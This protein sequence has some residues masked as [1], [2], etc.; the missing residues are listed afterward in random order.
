M[1][2]N[3]AQLIEK[4]ASHEG[5]VLGIYRIVYPILKGA[6]RSVL[7]ASARDLDSLDLPDTIQPAKAT[8]ILKAML[9]STSEDKFAFEWC[10][11]VK[12]PDGKSLSGFV[13]DELSKI[14]I[15]YHDLLPYLRERGWLKVE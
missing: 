14:G 3:E 4:I 1:S 13:R 9:G 5:D 7:P 15:S 2:E 8:A 11:A 6:D 10:Y 12:M